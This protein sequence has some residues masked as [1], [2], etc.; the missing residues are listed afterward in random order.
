MSTAAISKMKPGLSA[1][2]EIFL[3]EEKDTLFVPSLS[4]FDRDSTR[5]VYVK[6]KKEFIPVEV[7]TGTSG[8]S[9]TIIT[10]GLK[11]DEIIALTEPPFSL[12][13]DEK[14]RTDTTKNINNK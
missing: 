3:K 2:C 13:N 11:G 12:I 7:E 5:V 1:S 9:Y 10:G 6:S 4:I 14:A 8:S